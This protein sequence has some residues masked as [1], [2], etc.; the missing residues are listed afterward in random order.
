MPW[1][2]FSDGSATGRVGPGGGLP[3]RPVRARSLDA[4]GGLA[5]GEVMMRFE[6]LAHLRRMAPA[7]WPPGASR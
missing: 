4:A 6:E 5:E 1:A 3:A 7:E 2:R